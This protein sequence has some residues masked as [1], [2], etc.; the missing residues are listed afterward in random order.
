MGACAHRRP[1]ACAG[2]YAELLN[3]QPN[4]VS[5]LPLSKQRAWSSPLAGFQQ[6]LDPR[7]VGS[8]EVAG[9]GVHELRGA[10]DI[11]G[12]SPEVAVFHPASCGR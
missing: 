11:A 9:G 8:D 2:A 7:S 4:E 1:G 10:V 6:R 5:S 12:W 3:Q